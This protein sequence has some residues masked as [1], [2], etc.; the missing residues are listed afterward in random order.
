MHVLGEKLSMGDAIMVYRIIEDR[1]HDGTVHVH[2]M[3]VLVCLY[4]V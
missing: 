1:I 4:V 2:S 3:H